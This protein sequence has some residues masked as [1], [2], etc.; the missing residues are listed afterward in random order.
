MYLNSIPVEILDGHEVQCQSHVSRRSASVVL[1]VVQHH[2]LSVGKLVS[3][4]L[5]VL[6]EKVIEAVQVD[7]KECVHLLGPTTLY[8]RS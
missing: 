1:L 2:H 3:G 4:F 5:E 7:R 8:S 6:L